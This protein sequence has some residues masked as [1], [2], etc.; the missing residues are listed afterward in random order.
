MRKYLC[1]RRKWKIEDE[2]DATKVIN[3][4]YIYNTI[5]DLFY[6]CLYIYYQ[7]ILFLNCPYCREENTRNL[8]TYCVSSRSE[9]FLDSMVYFYCFHSQY[10]YRYLETQFQSMSTILLSQSSMKNKTMER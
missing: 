7:T 10:R 8:N 2:E 1:E 5:I 9:V 4:S 6:N 3:I